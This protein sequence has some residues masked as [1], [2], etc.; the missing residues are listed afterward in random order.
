MFLQTSI[1]KTLGVSMLLI[2]MV[3][4]TQGFFVP[5]SLSSSE[6]ERMSRLVTS[7]TKVT[8]THMVPSAAASS[9]SSSNV[10]GL[11]QSFA[12]GGGGGHCRSFG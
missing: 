6:Y 5:L 4:N 1:Y 12:L 3:S 9:S 8:T 11:C 2:S 7:K 10:H